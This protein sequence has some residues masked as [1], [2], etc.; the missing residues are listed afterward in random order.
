MTKSQQAQQFYL[1][2]EYYGNS[3]LIEIDSEKL[4]T[5]ERKKHLLFCLSYFVL[6]LMILII[7]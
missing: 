4:K 7:M 1:N 5:L 6:P 3:S 2:D